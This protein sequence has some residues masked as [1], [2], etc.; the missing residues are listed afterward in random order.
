VFQKI[1]RKNFLKLKL[2]VFFH[3]YAAYKKRRITRISYYM[4][5][6]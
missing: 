1:Y 3:Y 5:W 6:C 4:P 2:S